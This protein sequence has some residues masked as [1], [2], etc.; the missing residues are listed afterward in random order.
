MAPLLRL[1]TAQAGR[2]VGAGLRPE[3]GRRDESRLYVANFTCG[4][5]EEVALPGAICEAARLRRRGG[6]ACAL[7]GKAL[8]RTPMPVRLLALFPRVHA[9]FPSIHPMEIHFHPMDR[10]I[11]GM[12]FSIQGLFS[13]EKWPQ[14]VPYSGKKGLHRGVCGKAFD[15]TN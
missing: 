5:E 13:D 10:P 14:N 12:E 9:A 6:K 4:G 1:L 11:Q 2:N 15:V 8:M 3:R 7:Y